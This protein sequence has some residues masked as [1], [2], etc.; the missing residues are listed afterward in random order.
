MGSIGIPTG[1]PRQPVQLANWSNRSERARA[2]LAEIYPI[3]EWHEC[4]RAIPAGEVLSD[5]LVGQV[6]S[7]LPTG[8]GI[9]SNLVEQERSG[10]RQ[11]HPCRL[12]N[13]CCVSPFN[14]ICYHPRWRYTM[15]RSNYP[16]QREMGARGT[17]H[18]MRG[19]MNKWSGKIQAAM[20]KLTGKRGMQARG[21]GRQAGG[22]MQEGLGKAERKADDVIGD[23]R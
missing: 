6:A 5:F 11:P 7:G 16:P 1:A 21:T 12:G 22:S 10:Q 8:I 9:I 14:R 17:E 20:G 23:K 15:S 13:W 3:G 19:M 18:G 4:C 2:R